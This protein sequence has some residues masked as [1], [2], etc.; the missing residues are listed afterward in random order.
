MAR[1]RLEEELEEILRK[2]GKPARRRV[3]RWRAPRVHVPPFSP[4]ILLFAGV[5]LL[6]MALVGPLVSW[7][8]WL[9]VAGLG[10][11]AVAY[12]SY[13]IRRRPRIEKRWRGR[14]VDSG[15]N[16]WERLRR[17]FRR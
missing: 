10:L 4:G 7:G 9:L 15:P 12:G 11:L 6:V 2:A 5:I 16:W 8:V 17:P 13:W 3:R 1:G 14:P